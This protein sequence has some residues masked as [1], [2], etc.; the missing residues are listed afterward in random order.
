MH[1]HLQPSSFSGLCYLYDRVRFDSSD[2]TLRQLPGGGQ[3]W[4]CRALDLLAC[5]SPCP[6]CLS[7]NAH[8]CQ[9]KSLP[10]TFQLSLE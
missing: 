5:V 7:S 2:V 4:C 6:F 3:L 8:L 10:L 1:L 9:V